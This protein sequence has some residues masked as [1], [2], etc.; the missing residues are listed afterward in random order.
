MNFIPFLILNNAIIEYEFL[1]IHPHVPEFPK[2][3]LTSLEAK[4][5]FSIELNIA[6]NKIKNFRYTF[7]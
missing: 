2:R 7:E 1:R 6:F 4:A 3:V 5:H